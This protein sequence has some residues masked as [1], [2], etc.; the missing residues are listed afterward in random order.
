M[1][2]SLSTRNEV[3]DLGDEEAE[4]AL[5]A[6]RLAPAAGAFARELDPH[7]EARPHV[8]RLR[9]LQDQR[10]LGEVLD[11]R[12]D[13][14]TELRGQDHRLDVAVVLEAVADDEPLGL[15]LGERHHGEQFGLGAHLEAEAELAAVAVDFLDHQPLLVHLDREHRA[16]AALV[17]VLGDRGGERVAQPRQPVAQD[18]RE[19]HDDGRGQVARG[20][21]GDDLVQV[22]LATLRPVGTHDGVPCGIDAEVA[23]A[24]GIDA[25]QVERVL[26]APG[27][28]VASLAFRVF[29]C[30][31]RS[32]CSRRS[33]RKKEARTIV[34]AG[35][36][37]KRNLGEGAEGQEGQ[38]G[39]E[40]EEG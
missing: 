32:T 19:A 31:G 7:A 22:D 20:Q 5:L 39:Q 4:L 16:V 18:V 1:P 37:V 11:D 29:H 8:V 3:E 34:T 35:A 36:D 21:A 30:F 9:V 25:V 27:A 23:V 17:F 26:D 13:G 12:D 6:R 24:P 10:E 38:E 40:G 33:G 14:A 15:A 28:G 2:C